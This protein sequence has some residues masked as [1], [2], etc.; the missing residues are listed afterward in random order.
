M[1]M[2]GTQSTLQNADKRE[3]GSQHRKT[4]QNRPRD[5]VKKHGLLQERLYESKGNLL[6]LVWQKLLLCRLE[7]N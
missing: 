5:L 3:H 6:Q 4:K 7:A 2:R 1:F